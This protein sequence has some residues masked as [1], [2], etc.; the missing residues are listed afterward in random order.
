MGAGQNEGLLYVSCC[1]EKGKKFNVRVCGGGKLVS[2]PTQ[3]HEA[4]TS[5]F[6]KLAQPADSYA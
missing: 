4:W 1:H 6:Q 5:H 3:P 2:N